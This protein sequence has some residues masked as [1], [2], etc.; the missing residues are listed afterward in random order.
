MRLGGELR[1]GQNLKQRCLAYLRQANNSSFHKSLVAV[2][3][4]LLMMLAE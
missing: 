4:V 1:L 2:G 3:S